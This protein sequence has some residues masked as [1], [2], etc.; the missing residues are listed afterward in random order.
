[1]FDRIWVDIM[2]VIISCGDTRT[3]EYLVIDRIDNDSSEFSNES[4][5]INQLPLSHAHTP[6]YDI[7]SRPGINPQQCSYSQ[8]MYFYNFSSQFGRMEASCFCQIF[9]YATKLSCLAFR[10]LVAE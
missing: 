6:F 9:R 2:V 5:V 7:G 10:R 3:K 1:M 8:S 4:L